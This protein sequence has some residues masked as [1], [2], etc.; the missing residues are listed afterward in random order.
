MIQRI[1]KQRL[2]STLFVFLTF[3][4]LFGYANPE[5]ENVIALDTIKNTATLLK[6]QSS[7]YDT[8][9]LEGTY[10]NIT[11]II[12][13]FSKIIYS[14]SKDITPIHNLTRLY[15]VSMTGKYECH[16]QS[17]GEIF[18]KAILAHRAIADLLIHLFNHQRPYAYKR[19]GMTDRDDKLCKLCL[20]FYMP[21]VYF[22]KMIKEF[23]CTPP[24][25]DVF[26]Y[27]LLF[28]TVFTEV[29][30]NPYFSRRYL[31]NFRTSYL[32]E[33]ARNTRNFYPRNEVSR[34]LRH[35]LSEFSIKHLKMALNHK[36]IKKSAHEDGECINKIIKSFQRL[37]KVS[38][39]NSD[40][41]FLKNM[42][43][44][45]TNLNKLKKTVKRIVKKDD[46]KLKLPPLSKTRRTVSS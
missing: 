29:A 21:S 30:L 18:D 3:A 15:A 7:R 46:T 42:R 33:K 37:E 10:D 14:I 38:E 34:N 26:S 24:Y 23:S 35:F 39:K 40:P 12:S 36:A 1:K 25:T 11:S 20:Y 13:Q 5:A 27:H 32:K 8:L 45:Q 28:A 31:N 22:T 16:S 2:Y 4:P 19:G 9:F 17:P 43:L 44:A 41:T 6:T